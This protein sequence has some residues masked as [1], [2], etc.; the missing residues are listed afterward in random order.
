MKKWWNEI[1]ESWRQ[2]DGPDGIV[3]PGW[4]LFQLMQGWNLMAGL[5]GAWGR[6][7]IWVGPV[8]II[9]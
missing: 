4:P 5:T 6:P 1:K 7:F 8:F 2:A 9:F 3:Y